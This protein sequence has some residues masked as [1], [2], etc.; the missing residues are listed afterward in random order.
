[1]HCIRS[2]GNNVLYKLMLCITF[3]STC[4]KQKE[5]RKWKCDTIYLMLRL[6]FG[7]C[8]KDNVLT[9]FRPYVW[10]DRIQEVEFCDVKS[11]KLELISMAVGVISIFI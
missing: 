6:A 8:V 1:M 11:R 5:N 4:N 7:I 10:V 2:F 3:L 9:L